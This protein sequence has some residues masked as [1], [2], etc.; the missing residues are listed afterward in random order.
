MCTCH[1]FTIILSSFP[2]IQPQ[3]AHIRLSCWAEML[4]VRPSF[5]MLGR[6][7]PIVCLWGRIVPCDDV[8]LPHDP[9]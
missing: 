2:E 3:R 8:A 7:V 4:R 9:W 5:C 6:P 1:L